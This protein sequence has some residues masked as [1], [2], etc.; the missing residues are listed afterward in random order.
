MSMRQTLIM[1]CACCRL[2]MSRHA[3]GGTTE[4]LKA[5]VALFGAKKSMLSA[6]KH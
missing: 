4:G 1:E 5:E 2:S 3:P 6:R